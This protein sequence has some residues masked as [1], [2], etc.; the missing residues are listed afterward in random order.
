[1]KKLKKL[2]NVIR[3]FNC[4]GMEEAGF[5]SFDYYQNRTKCFFMLVKHYNEWVV[6]DINQTGPQNLTIGQVLHK[7][8]TKVQAKAFMILYTKPQTPT[9][10]TLQ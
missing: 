1:M 6:F 2:K 10:K 7:C 8:P 5:T 3:T 4:E 9:P